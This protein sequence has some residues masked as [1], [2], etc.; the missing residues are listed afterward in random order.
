MPLSR[1]PSNANVSVA[2]ASGVLTRAQRSAAVH[3]RRRLALTLQCSLCSAAASA[4]LEELPIAKSIAQHLTARELL[5][6]LL[7]GRTPAWRKTA[8]EE[9]A[10]R[11][12][13]SRQRVSLLS[14]IASGV[15]D[16]S[17]NLLD[18]EKAPAAAAERAKGPEDAASL[19]INVLLVRLVVAG[20]EEGRR[21]LGAACAAALTGELPDFTR[22]ARLTSA[23]KSHGMR[24]LPPN[25]AQSE[26]FGAFND[27]AQL[28]LA[29]ETAAASTP[30]KALDLLPPTARS[31][32]NAF[33]VQAHDFCLRKRDIRRFKEAREERKA[34]AI[35]AKT[36][37][38][39]EGA[40]LT[41]WSPA[42]C[43]DDFFVGKLASAS[44]ASHALASVQQSTWGLLTTFPVGAATIEGRLHPFNEANKTRLDSFRLKQRE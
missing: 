2:R 36:D 19:R 11:H 37:A 40:S 17:S 14:L 20:G 6:S 13:Y 22:L 7:F 41:H 18:P 23:S 43:I 1:K 38:T 15:S 32:F 28:R 5:D 44:P 34:R 3:L 4:L 8:L 35:G 39:R 10:A 24:A 12:W 31:A 16:V 33:L 26:A 25:L 29:N 9:L 30:E 27:L 21:E 42:P